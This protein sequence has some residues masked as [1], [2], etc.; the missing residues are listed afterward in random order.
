MSNFVC[1]HF[2]EDNNANSFTD[3]LYEEWDIDEDAISE[4]ATIQ[5]T[6]NS[7]ALFDNASKNSLIIKRDCF[8]KLKPNSSQDFK[9]ENINSANHCKLEESTLDLNINKQ[10]CKPS[11]LKEEISMLLQMLISKNK[12]VSSDHITDIINEDE[13]IYNVVTMRDIKASF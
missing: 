9:F 7:S 13:P 2:N 1:C 8:I 12:K 3:D 5:L 4:G 10:N 6:K 11:S